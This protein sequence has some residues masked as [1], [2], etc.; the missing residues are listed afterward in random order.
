MISRTHTQRSMISDWIYRV[1]R[2]P[3]IFWR[4]W[5]DPDY[6]FPLLRWFIAARLLRP[7]EFGAFALGRWF[8]FRRNVRPLI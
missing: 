8:K 3:Q 6:P 7:K 2:I 4:E 1:R 5:A